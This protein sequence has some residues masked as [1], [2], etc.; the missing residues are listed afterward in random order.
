V[1]ATTANHLTFLPR[2]AI[3]AQYMLSPCV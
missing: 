2:D 1:T 3:L